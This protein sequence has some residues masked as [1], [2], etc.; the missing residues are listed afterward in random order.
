MF[1]LAMV[2]VLTWF[3]TKTLA[4]YPGTYNCS[5]DYNSIK[6]CDGNHNDMVAMLHLGSG[7][8]YS[9]YTESYLRLL[10]GENQCKTPMS[11]TTY[12]RCCV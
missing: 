3:T 6:V 12:V 11:Y 8:L 1:S 5:F 2:A 4:C 7:M 10:I 9:S